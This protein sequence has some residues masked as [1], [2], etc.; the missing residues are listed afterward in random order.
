MPAV[1]LTIFSYLAWCAK[2]CQYRCENTHGLK[3]TAYMACSF[4]QCTGLGK[5]CVVQ[6]PVQ[7]SSLAF[8][9]PAN[10]VRRLTKMFSATISA[11]RTLLL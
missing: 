10:P 5:K 11:S 6:I 8:Q 4:V 1:E 2:V 3:A 9:Q 7:L